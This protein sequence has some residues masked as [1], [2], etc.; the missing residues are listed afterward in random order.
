MCVELKHI[1]YRIPYRKQ[2]AQEKSYQKSLWV[3]A[4][5]LMSLH[6]LH[7]FVVLSIGNVHKSSKERTRLQTLIT[8]NFL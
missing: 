2:S 3:K 7:H 4:L 6:Y 1:P 8:F 5:L